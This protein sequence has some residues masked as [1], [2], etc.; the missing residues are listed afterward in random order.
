MSRSPKYWDQCLFL[1]PHRFKK[2]VFLKNWTFFE[3]PSKRKN[4][5]TF[6]TTTLSITTF[7]ISAFSITTFSLMALY[8]DCCSAECR[9]CC[10]SQISH[11]SWVSLCWMPLWRMFWRQ[12]KIDLVFCIFIGQK[13]NLRRSMALDQTHKTF[14]HT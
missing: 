3:F 12:R 8:I 2:I 6:N 13:N 11:L 14:L 9:L 7:S 4:T 5:T 10:V 1:E